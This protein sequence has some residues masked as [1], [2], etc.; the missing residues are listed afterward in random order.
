MFIRTESLRQFIRFYPVVTTIIAIQLGV[1]LIVLIFPFIQSLLSP[2]GVIIPPIG[3]FLYQWGTGVNLYI[4]Q[5]EYWRL[6][7]SIFLHNP[8]GVMHVLFNSFSLVLFGPALEQMLG[9][10]KFITVYL[11]A[12]I[13]GNVCTWLMDP[14][15]FYFHLGASGAIYGLFGLYMFMIFFEKHLI[16]RANAQII[17]IILIIGLVMTFLRPGI[18]VYAH[19]FGFIGGVALGPIFLRNAQPFSIWKNTS[20]PRD[21]SIQFNPNR[22]RKKR[23]PLKNVFWIVIIILVLIG[24]FGRF[25]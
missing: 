2:F 14:N 16:D 21:D 8:Y 12:G 17:M 25:L 5:G 11:L 9:K 7:T 3:D 10:V 20:S 6:V 23:F 19:V 24:L 4:S 18:N 13:I 1:W 22:W 15:A